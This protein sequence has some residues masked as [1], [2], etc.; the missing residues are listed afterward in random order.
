MDL[1]AHPQCDA[2]LNIKK[3]HLK[4][5]T[6]ALNQGFDKTT[7]DLKPDHASNELHDFSCFSIFAVL[8][9]ACLFIWRFLTV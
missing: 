3:V 9:F 1:N 6:L 8:Y 2:G 7:H 4:N 5:K